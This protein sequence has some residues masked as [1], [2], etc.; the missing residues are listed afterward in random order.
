M[1]EII[2]PFY[3]GDKFIEIDGNR[4]QITKNSHTTIEFKSKDVR[5]KLIGRFN[6]A[7]KTGTLEE[8]KDISDFNKKEGPVVLTYDRLRESTFTCK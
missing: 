3:I 8:K 1:G 5:P 4:Y 7:A 6:L 2:F